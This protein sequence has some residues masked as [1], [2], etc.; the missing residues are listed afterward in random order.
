MM[1]RP[2]KLEK[3]QRYSVPAH[4]NTFSSGADRMNEWRWD[5]GGDEVGNEGG[6]FRTQALGKGGMWEVAETV[7]GYKSL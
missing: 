5:D 2:G 7:I 4:C 6:K 1:K 3:E